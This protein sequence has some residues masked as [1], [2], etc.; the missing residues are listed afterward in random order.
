MLDIMVSLSL[1]TGRVGSL[2]LRN[3]S[4]G[5]ARFDTLNL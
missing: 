3:G 4:L 5:A 2:M 1:V